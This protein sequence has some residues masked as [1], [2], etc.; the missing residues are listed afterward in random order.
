M[1]NGL[2]EDSK[3]SVEEVKK[4]LSDTQETLR[5]AVSEC[6][7]LKETNDIQSNLWKIWL[8]EHNDND[9]KKTSNSNK[10]VSDDHEDA[11]LVIVFGSVTVL[12][13]GDRHGIEKIKGI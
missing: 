13:T 3:K 5:I 12:T 9:G 7:K 11:A 2:K 6:E 1:Y 4:E 10:D 8:K